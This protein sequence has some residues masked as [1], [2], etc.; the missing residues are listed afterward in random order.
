V[1]LLLLFLLL[2]LP[3]LLLLLL[4]CLIVSKGLAGACLYGSKELTKGGTRYIRRLSSE[5]V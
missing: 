5:E 3:L 1:V 4:L 2:L